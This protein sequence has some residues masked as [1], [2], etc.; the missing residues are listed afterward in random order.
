MIEGFGPQKCQVLTILNLEII[1]NLKK[2][3][4]QKNSC[5]YGNRGLSWVKE[6]VKVI[7]DWCLRGLR[8]ICN[9]KKILLAIDA[10]PMQEWDEQGNFLAFE[11]AK[12]EA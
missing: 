4:N 2:A 10:S 9:Q 5:Y 11:S 1:K 12:S 7:P 3:N 8:K 6:V